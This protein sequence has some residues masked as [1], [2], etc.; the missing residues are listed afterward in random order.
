MHLPKSWGNPDVAVGERLIVVGASGVR[1]V[2]GGLIGE[3]GDK[4][5]KE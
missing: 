3:G 1:R 4:L 2:F 5:K